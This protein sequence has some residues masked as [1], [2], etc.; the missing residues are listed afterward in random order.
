MKSILL[1]EDSNADQFIAKTMISRLF[2]DVEI[3]QAYDGIEALEVLRSLSSPPNLILLDIN[4]PR[5][6]G[7]D[8]LDSLCGEFPEDYPPIV[9]LTSSDQENDRLKARKYNCVNGYLLKP[10]RRHDVVSLTKFAD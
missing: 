8:F 3:L 2:P 9:M 6:N 10:L 4:M 7:F 1:I 5:M